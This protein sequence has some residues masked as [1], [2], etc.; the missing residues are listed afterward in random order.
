[1]SASTQTGRL[2]EN[3]LEQAGGVVAIDCGHFCTVDVN[4]IDSTDR[5]LSTNP[6]NVITGKSEGRRRA[7]RIAVCVTSATVFS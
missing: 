1:M 3:L 5:G 2:E 6:L 7:R 4:S